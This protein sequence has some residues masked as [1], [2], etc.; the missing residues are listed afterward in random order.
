M[1][2]RTPIPIA[3]TAAPATSIEIRTGRVLC[4]FCCRLWRIGQAFSIRQASGR[5]R[6]RYT[7]TSP[8]R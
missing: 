5:S 3:P 8:N 2:V 1:K 7:D 4:I 6:R